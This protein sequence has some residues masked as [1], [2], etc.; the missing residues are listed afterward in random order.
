M[1]YARKKDAS[2]SVIV[3]TL[4]AVGAEVEETYRTPGML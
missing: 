1:N 2:H 3:Q 4:R